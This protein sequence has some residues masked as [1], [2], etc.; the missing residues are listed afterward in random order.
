LLSSASTTAKK[1]VHRDYTDGP[2]SDAELENKDSLGEEGIAE[3]AQEEGHGHGG[4][5]APP[6]TRKKALIILIVSTIAFGLLAELL[7]QSV[8]YVIQGSGISEKF[9]GVTLFAIV[10]LFFFPP[11]KKN[12]FLN[13][14]RSTGPQRHRVRQR[15]PL[16]HA[17][18]H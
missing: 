6:W 18:K 10:R 15:Y 9:I 5:G 7:V 14:N 2:M 16:C 13:K 8:D 17:Q 12:F 3:H 1:P 4:H 11:Q